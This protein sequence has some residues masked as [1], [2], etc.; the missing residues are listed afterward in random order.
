VSTPAT[1]PGSRRRGERDPLIIASRWTDRAIADLDAELI[2][3]VG[4]QHDRNH[5]RAAISRYGA[6]CAMTAVAAV[7]DAEAAE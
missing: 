4:N 6:L 7:S 2:A 3:R 5:L 1:I